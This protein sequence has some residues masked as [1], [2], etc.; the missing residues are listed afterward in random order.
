MIHK[1]YLIT[2]VL[3]G[4]HF[5]ICQTLPE[6][7]SL[8]EALAFGEQNNRNIKKASMEI[9]KAYKDQW[10]T[11]AIGLPQISANA[12][13]QNFI[14]LPTSLIPAQFFG[15]NEGEF[16]EVQFGTPQT[17][18]AGLT[19]QQLIFDGSY[20]VGLEAS[21]IFLKISENI[22]EKTLLEVRRNIVQTYSSVLLARENIDFLKKN[23]NNLEKN[24]LELNQL[25][26]NGFEEEESVEQI[27]LTLSG[28]KTQLRYINNVER[29]TLDMLKLLM[30]FPIKSP[31]ILS[32]DLEKLTNDSLFNFKVPENLSLDNNIDIKI[33]EN[34][35]LSE[36]LLYRYE[37]SKGLPRLSAFLNGNY[38]GNSESFTFTQQGQKWFGAALL[39]INLQIPVFSS[40]RRSALSQKAK[41][42]MLQ[43]ENDLT[44][45]QERILIEVK[46]AEN[47]YKLAVE[48]YFTNKENLELATRIE[49]K[50][51]LKYFEGVTSSFELREAQ[52][53][54]YS[55]QNNYIKSIQE[56]IQKKLSLQTIL[57]TT[58]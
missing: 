35:L 47:D 31:L 38:T 11:I 52:L 27:R 29:I 36:T 22:F 7:V 24:L 16:A 46:A 58:Q 3:F 40:L 42:A 8:E 12:D 34:N 26:E 25:Y 33:A 18:T 50:N 19:L 6:L 53:Q 30:G 51:Q 13:Y 44:E 43:A 9:R 14:E 41:I 10:S 20:I 23:K 21:K 37:R 55:A 1:I 39:G 49:K 4:L 2:F 48:N 5:P 28:V 32:D 56:V 57:N 45:T 54:L 15:G 17:M